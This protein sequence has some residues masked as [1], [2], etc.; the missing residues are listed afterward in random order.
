[1]NPQSTA[2][3]DFVQAKPLADQICELA[4]IQSPDNVIVTTFKNAGGTV[5][6]EKHDEPCLVELHGACEFHT[7]SPALCI[8]LWAQ[9]VIDGFPTLQLEPHEVAA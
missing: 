9:T 2:M 8:Y 7:S 5:F 3:I 4:H 6:Q 1:M